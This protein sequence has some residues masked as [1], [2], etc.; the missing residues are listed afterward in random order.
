MTTRK[1]PNMI[2]RIIPAAFLLATSLHALTSC[3]HS[4]VE[5]SF[6]LQATHDLYYYG[7]GPALRSFITRGEDKTSWMTQSQ[8]C[9]A[10]SDEGS[11]GSTC[12][13]G[14]YALPYDHVR[15]PGVVPRTFAGA[16]VLASMAKVISFISPQP[17]SP[18]FVQF[19]IR[20]LLLLLCLVAHVRLALALEYYSVSKPKS[21]HTQAKK[22]TSTSIQSSHPSISAY[23][24]LITASQFHIPFYSSRLLPNTF[25]LLLVILAYAEWFYGRPRCTAVFLVFTTAIFRCDVLLL[26]FT[27]GLT[28]LLQRRLNIVEAI[29][30]GIVTGVASLL[31]T[32]PLDTLLWS[33]LIWPEFEVWWFN[34]VD[35]RSGEW[36]RMVWHWYFSRALPK[37]MMTTALLFPLAFVRLPERIDLWITRRRSG[38]STRKDPKKHGGFFDLTLLPFF[39]PILGYIA[40]YSCLP[41]KE[42]RFIFPAIPMLNVFAAYAMSRL[43][44]VAFPV[45]DGGKNVPEKYS[46]ADQKSA[47]SAYRLNFHWTG[48]FM[49][50]CGIGTILTTMIGSQ[51]FIR[52]SM[53]NYPGG[54][55]LNRLRRHLD[56]S[57]P[58]SRT[59]I[60][61]INLQ[62]TPKWE[63][64]R[65][66]VD[67]AAAMTGVSLFGQRHASR[68]YD[69][70]SPFPIEKSGYEDENQLEGNSKRTK[71]FTHL[72]SEEQNV[73]GYHLVD[74]VKGYP[75]FDFKNFRIDT[76]NATYILES[77]DWPGGEMSN[78]STRV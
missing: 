78:L 68:R 60:H 20:F 26:L 24:L 67:V 29:S 9:D 53:E 16:F 71:K 70:E 1:D 69:Y 57:I 33:R 48:F 36:G 40:L 58:S 61:S 46:S 5:E 11:D 39:L 22:S 76:R 2:F 51:L 45:I 8:T 15:F 77:D 37:G 47:S 49:W 4:K 38:Q 7:L 34:T 50:L 62:N 32:V 30:I 18:I 13:V 72:L 6:N 75:R 23:Y 25:A 31:V 65:V 27:V 35:N 28:L 44:K 55:A 66:H 21:H 73:D 63:D 42:I 3:P 54:E 12:V 41:H 56:S 59:T 17:M 52:L 14:D 43:H 64:V 10:R 74:V 19:L